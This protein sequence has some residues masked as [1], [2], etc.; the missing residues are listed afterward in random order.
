MA[1]DFDLQ[2]DTH[3][4]RD[5]NKILQSLIMQCNQAGYSVKSNCHI[6]FLTPYISALET[7]FI[8]TYFLFG[9]IKM[10]NDTTSLMEQLMDKMASINQDL[11]KMQT[12]RRFMTGQQLKDTI[13]RCTTLQMLIMFGLQQRKMLVRM[14]ELEPKGAESIAHWDKKSGFS[15]GG[16]KLDNKS[17]PNFEK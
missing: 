5:F 11:Y 15:K 10:H 4:S 3:L 13:A 16:L 12:D 8:N 6:D 2:T 17:I 14:S 1:E 9:N 7:L